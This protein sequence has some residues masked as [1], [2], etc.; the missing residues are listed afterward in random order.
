MCNGVEAGLLGRNCLGAKALI[1]ATDIRNNKLNVF[2]ALDNI[3]EIV[4]GGVL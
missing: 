1:G 2:I 4:I 3:E